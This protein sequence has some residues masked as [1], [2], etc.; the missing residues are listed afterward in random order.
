MYSHYT[1][2]PK[3][4][5]LLETFLVTVL[6]AFIV[7][8]VGSGIGYWTKQKKMDD[9]RQGV[10]SLKRNIQG[11]YQGLDGYTG[12]TTANANRLQLAANTSFTYN[13][14]QFV[15]LNGKTID[16][17][18]ATSGGFPVF[19]LALNSLGLDECSSLVSSFLSDPSFVSVNLN[20]TDYGVSSSAN[21]AN[22]CSDGNDVVLRFR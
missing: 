16:V 8:L 12:L 7:L 4:M 18:P 22:S 11:Y 13:G 17:T 2:R 10:V 9:L 19:E 15:T 1:S 5:S 3:G 14:T 21:A 20:G 6:G